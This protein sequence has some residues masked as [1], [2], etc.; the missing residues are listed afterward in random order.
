M[1]NQSSTE[2]FSQWKNVRQFTISAILFALI[3]IALFVLTERRIGSTPEVD[4]SSSFNVLEIH[5]STLPTDPPLLLSELV[6][7]S[8]EPS[9]LPSADTNTVKPPDKTAETAD[10]LKEIVV[11]RGDSLST[12]F[13]RA[14]LT[15]QEL[16]AVQ[17]ASPQDWSLQHIDVGQKIR[18]QTDEDG[19][20]T[21][22]E[23]ERDFLNSVMF[24]R[25]DDGFTSEVHSKQVVAKEIYHS[26]EIEKGQSVISA[27]LAAGI[28]SEKTL[29]TIPKLLQWEI[30]FY[31]DIHPGDAYEILYYEN[32]VE[33]EYFGDGD[34]IAL[35]FTNTGERHEI[36]RYQSDDIP[37]GYFERDGVST[38]KRF[39]RTPV[40]Y[41]R[42]S[43][44]FNPKRLH[45]IH[46]VV[47]PHN[48]I[49]YAAPTGTPVYATGAG[50]VERAS[51]TR[52]NGN[53]V[54]LKHGPI[55]TTK[56]LHLHRIDPAMKVGAKVKQGQ[57]IGSVGMTG[58]A[59]G[60]HLH[61]E[62][63]VNGVH[64]NPKT[65]DLPDGEPLSAEQIV[66]F[67]N[68]SDDIFAR[69]EQLK[70]AYEKSKSLLTTF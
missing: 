59:T 70:T 22:F 16:H 37:L 12:I 9:R 55:Y 48:G 42:V 15:A 46:K 30:D 10:G 68:H 38:Q 61:Y 8:V 17:Q 33:G 69:M 14:K 3:T 19:R 23:Y 20:L 65:V 7:N 50:I 5:T 40:E 25:T 54:V 28:Q 47:M 34:I 57:R 39:L 31:H 53:Y 35:I 6:D 1:A 36:V 18:Y 41:K 44:E 67:K 64:K 27:G 63:L 29:W 43:S 49:D 51:K 60:P 11:R 2:R 26:V 4:S 21:L 45:P 32:Y 62:F 52:A 56:Y 13:S 66:L 24:T 58:Y